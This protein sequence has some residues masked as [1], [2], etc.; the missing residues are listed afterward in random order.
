MKKSA[1]WLLSLLLVMSVFLAACSGGGE[2]AST[3]KEPKDDG[4]ASGEAQEGGTVTFGYTQPFKGVLSYAYYEGEDDVNALKFMHEGIFNTSEELTTVPGLADWEM[5]EDN[6]KLTIKF[7]EGIKWHDGEEL[8]V[9]D[10]EYAWYLIADPTYEGARFA[11]VEMIKGAQEYKDG[12]ADKIEGIKIIDDYTIEVTVKSPTVNLIDNIWSYPE[13]KHYYGDISSKELPDSDQI[14]KNPIGIG[15]FKVKN[16]VPGEMIE[17]ERFD[18]YWQGKPKLDGIVYKI[19]DGSLTQGLVQN[20]E[21][22][23]IEAPK[24]QWET[25]KALDNVNPQEVD[26][27]SYSYIAFDWGHYDTKKGVVVSDNKKFQNKNLRHAMAHAI[28]R[29]AFI[30]GFANGLGKPLNTPFP[31]VSWAKIDESEINAY[32]FDQEK[33][34]KLLD[35]A[36]YVD[37]DG[38]GFREDPEGKP[39]TIN[40]DAMAGAETSEARAQFILQ[41]WQEVGLNAKLNGGSLKDFNLFYDTIEADD[42]SVE[43]FMGA[44]GLASD[45]D[46]A[47]IWLSTDKWN[48]WRWYSEESDALIKKGVTFPE[49]PSKDVKEHR[50]EIYNEWQKLVNEELPVIFFEQR[51]DAWAVNKRVGGVKLYADGVM[52][53][54]VYNWHIVE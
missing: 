15:P 26:A 54:E 50:Q 37:K 4:K 44:W 1:L 51:V 2:K 35:E 23:V 40:F 30:D 19:I 16:I 5:S 31:S 14:R 7:K 32:E 22:D 9:E 21:I 52:P 39:F 27:L 42:P 20:G 33:A 49:D 18:D 3:D 36:G 17:F 41:S 24:D 28:D 53:N 10:L 13:P 25:I 6:T 29:Q 34:K 43:T 12:K 11:N 48:M 45:P 46:P 8:T 47:G 38:D